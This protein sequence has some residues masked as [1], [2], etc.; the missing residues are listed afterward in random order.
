MLDI[1]IPQKSLDMYIPG[2]YN[3]PSWEVLLRVL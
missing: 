1:S 3:K 2:I